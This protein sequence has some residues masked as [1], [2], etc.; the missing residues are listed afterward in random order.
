MRRSCILI[1][2]SECVATD[3]L[4][5]V[6]LCNISWP[7]TR[8]MN[9]LLCSAFGGLLPLPSQLIGMEAEQLQT[10][11]GVGACRHC[12]PVI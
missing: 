11:C 5:T 6:T 10:M 3:A 2:V 9:R 1:I 7:G 8:R 4:R 12:C